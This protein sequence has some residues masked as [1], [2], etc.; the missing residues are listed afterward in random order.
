MKK[1]IATIVC[2]MCTAV[3]CAQLVWLSVDKQP[4]AGTYSRNFHQLLTA[5]QNQAALAYIPVVTAGVST[6]QR[7]LL[8]AISTHA[9]ALAV[10]VRHGGFGLHLQQSGYTDYRRQ[11]I[12]LSYGRTVGDRFSIGMQADYL[13]E[14]IPQYSTAATVVFELGCLMHLTPQLHMGLHVFNPTAG[15]SQSLG[16]NKVPAIYSAGLGYEV[17]PAFLLSIA[18][19]QETGAATLAKV[20][21][22][23]RIVKQLSLQLGMSTDPQL[24]SIAIGISLRRLYI[25][26]SASHHPQLGLT[27]ATAIVWQLKQ[28]Q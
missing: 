23:Y 1:I 4:F 12:G 9:A 2:T 5:L 18:V 17:T 14:V 3:I 15:S 16:K 28:Q 26:L 24:N 10:P 7:F 21:C 20:M 25:Q 19:T 13:S 6:E 8:K 22:E 27:P 11:A